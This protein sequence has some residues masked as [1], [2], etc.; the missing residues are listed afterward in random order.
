[1]PSLDMGGS[2]AELAIEDY[3]DAV[4]WVGARIRVTRS[5]PGRGLPRNLEQI[6]FR[7]L[8]ERYASDVRRFALYLC[9]DRA[10]ADDNAAEAFARAW[11]R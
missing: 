7:G 3:P 11:T 6:D 1:M 5:S 9:A 2:G 4:P 10:R 8:Y